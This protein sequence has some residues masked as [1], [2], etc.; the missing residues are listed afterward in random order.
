MLARQ[1]PEA[2]RAALDRSPERPERFAVDEF[3]DRARA[4]AGGK[5]RSAGKRTVPLLVS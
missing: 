2:L 4:R 5:G 1:L 3:L